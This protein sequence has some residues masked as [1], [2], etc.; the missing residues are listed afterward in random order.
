MPSRRLTRRKFLALTG[1]TAAHTAL[2]AAPTPRVLPR[3]GAQSLAGQWRF[4]LDRDDTG[5]ASAWFAKQLPAETSIQLPGILQ[6][7]GYG[8]EIT[9]ETQFVAALP[10]DMRWYL[11]PQYQNY[12]KPGHV[13]VPYLSQPV[14]HYLGVAWYQREIDVPAAWRGKRIALTLERTRWLTDVYVDDKL[15]GS[16]RSLVAPHDFTLGTL[17]PGKHRLSIRIDNRMLQPPYRPDGHAVSDAEGSTWNGIVGRIELSAT[18]SVWIDDAQVF[19]ALARKSAEIKIKVGNISGRVGSGTVRAV[20]KR[21][22]LLGVS[23]SRE[24]SACKRDSDHRIL[25][26]SQRRTRGG[27]QGSVPLRR[28]GEAVS[29]PGHDHRADLLEPADESEPHLDAG[30]V[31]TRNIPRL[32]GFR[33]SRTAIGSGL[34]CCRRQPR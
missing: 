7:Q 10:R 2:Y 15:I 9:A 3:D 27:R 21:V 33:R 17:L 30:P 8:D 23:N 1:A 11:L 29:R 6:T 19:P 28:A 34:I 12:T 25:A 24:G 13:E 22:G 20:P 26:R 5:V 31:A 16:N 32:P 14:R 4:A 18:S